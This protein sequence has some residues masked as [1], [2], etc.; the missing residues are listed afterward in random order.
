ME[1][2]KLTLIMPTFNSCSQVSPKTNLTFLNNSLKSL[3]SQSFK[4]FNFII[5]DNKSD[6]QTRD[7]ISNFQAKDSRLSLHVDSI[8]RG[9][10]EAI[11]KLIEL[12]PTEYCMVVNDDDYWHPNYIE[13]L[14]SELEG[15]QAY[16]AYSN[17]NYISITDK[18]L[19]PL[20][21]IRSFNY[22][23]EWSALEN[24]QHYVV[25][26]N[27]FPI[28]FGIWNTAIFQDEYPKYLFDTYRANV[29]NLFISNVLHRTN[30]IK[31]VDKKLFFYRSK[32]RKFDYS[33]AF[34][35]EQTPANDR[36]IFLRLA[37]HQL[38]FVKQLWINHD[39]SAPINA[40]NK[41]SG[42][43]MIKT[44]TISLAKSLLRM[45]VWVL[46]R[47]F[48]N[49]SDFY[50]IKKFNEEVR[51]LFIK[52]RANPSMNS[53]ILILNEFNLREISCFMESNNPEVIIPEII[54]ELTFF[55][56]VI[57]QIHPEEL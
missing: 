24:Y 50:A 33:D 25:R 37:L 6:D 32:S 43:I 15:S 56:H 52:L 23:E 45:E 3:Q 26:R 19:Q 11:S 12:V 31:Y 44:I 4:N 55:S 5:L 9:P 34:P 17:G 22:S 39:K 8:R 38:R 53:S 51:S 29:D 35:G 46:G 48:V 28:T 47:K 27:P 18:I 30:K 13:T 36:E 1:K 16:L 42:Y 2:V 20:N 41:A 49:K 14:M 40:L 7:I 21:S 54:N 57:S 10:E